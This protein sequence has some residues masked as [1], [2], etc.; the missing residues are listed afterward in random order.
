MLHSYV[1]VICELRLFSISLILLYGRDPKIKA[2]QLTRSINVLLVDFNPFLKVEGKA[3][4]Y[5]QSFLGYKDQNGIH[6][7][8]PPK[9]FPKQF[10]ALPTFGL[11]FL[12]CYA[13]AGVA[14]ELMD[15]A[16][17]CNFLPHCQSC[18]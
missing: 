2:W 6:P 11:K 17:P 18:C 14:L 15:V 16:L 9:L 10:P 13:K 1:T 8:R 7:F 4:L 3:Q 12:I 5:L